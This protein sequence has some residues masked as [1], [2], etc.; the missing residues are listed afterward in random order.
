MDNDT[1]RSLWSKI[2]KQHSS[3]KQSIRDTYKSKEMTFSQDITLFPQQQTF[4]GDDTIHSGSPLTNTFSN[5]GTIYTKNRSPVDTFS[6]DSTVSPGENSE[7]NTR[8]TFSEDATV[9]SENSIAEVTSSIE[10]TLQN[11]E[12]IQTTFDTEKDYQNYQEINR[13]GMGIIYRAEQV[14]LKRKI[15]IKKILSQ[16]DKNKFLA[17][18]L[19]TAYLDHPNIIPVYEIDQNNDG[20]ILLAMKLVK[21]ISWKNLLYPETLEHEDKAK[22]YNL[23]KHLEILISVC[24]AVNYAHSKGIVHCDLKPDNIM[25]G[26]FGEVLVMDWGIAVDIRDRVDEKRTFHKNDIT[27]PMGTPCYMSPE[28]AEGRGKDISS[29]TD[30]YLLGGILYEI[31]QRRPPHDGK[32]MWLVLLAAKEGKPVSFSENTPLELRQVCHKAMAQ[33]H[34]ERYQNAILFKKA[35]ENYLQHRDSIKISNKAQQILENSQNTLQQ[36][37]QIKDNQQSSDT[38]TL[39]ENLPQAIFG[40]D[41][42]VDLWSGN[43]Q[44]IHGK[45]QARLTYAKVAFMNGDLTLAAGQ[46]D[47]LSLSQIEDMEHF[48]SEVNA[49][50]QKIK[51]AKKNRHYLAHLN[52]PNVEYLEQEYSSKQKAKENLKKAVKSMKKILPSVQTAYTS[53]GKT[54][55]QSVIAMLV[56]GIPVA[57]FFSLMGIA[58]GGFVLGIGSLFLYATSFL[59]GVSSWYAPFC[60]F[61]AIHLWLFGAP[62]YYLGSFITPIFLIA[63][64]VGLMITYSGFKWKNRSPKIAAI[65]AFLVVILGAYVGKKMF[66]EAVAE[67][68]YPLNT[69]WLSIFFTPEAGD[70]SDFLNS[71]MLNSTFALMTEVLLILLASVGAAIAAFLYTKNFRFSEKSQQFLECYISPPLAIEAVLGMLSSVREGDYSTLSTFLSHK[72]DKSHFCQVFVDVLPDEKDSDYGFLEIWCC[73]Q[74][75]WKKEILKDKW[76]CFSAPV[77]SEILVPLIKSNTLKKDTTWFRS[78]G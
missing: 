11:K 64:F 46:L 60:W 16:V 59:F 40:F 20:D 76:L 12:R 74:V 77:T 31:L 24:N 48:S 43:E 66:L 78:Y 50:E 56:L 62:F 51:S 34:N 75:N 36:L 3:Q 30:V 49:L 14:K 37:E 65:F 10:S 8:D 15:A 19:V 52:L 55:L 70:Q 7:N 44:A 73:L 35:V 17:E 5:D 13:G 53:S 61:L 27:T 71:D 41:E 54:T 45:L 68:N 6:E 9:S 26:D 2:L 58:V 69:A 18:S 63:F 22:E 39:Y 38:K 33:N 23:Q 21:G 47:K 57:C 67:K 28:L 25:I 72:R 29:A 32:S 1:F 4:S 42:A